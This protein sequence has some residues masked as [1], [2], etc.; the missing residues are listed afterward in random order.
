MTGEEMRKIIESYRSEK[1][2]Y[3]RATLGLFGVDWPPPKGWKKEL[4][5]EADNAHWRFLYKNY[6][7]RIINE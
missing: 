4:I 5:K 2:G 6:K 1:G 7:N 3:T